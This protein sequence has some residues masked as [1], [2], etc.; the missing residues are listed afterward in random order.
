MP[1]VPALTPGRIP[2]PSEVPLAH[3]LN[4]SFAFIVKI[5]K[6]GGLNAKHY[7]EITPCHLRASEYYC[8]ARALAS[9]INVAL[10]SEPK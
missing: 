9:S 10:V 7:C 4:H 6:G 1:T 5:L 3:K 2:V 8:P